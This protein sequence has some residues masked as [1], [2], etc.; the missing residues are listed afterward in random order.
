M[1]LLR[2]LVPT[3]E[4]PMARVG[5]LPLSL[6]ALGVPAATAAARGGLRRGL[7][8]FRGCGGGLPRGWFRFR[9]FGGLWIPDRDCGHVWGGGWTPHQL[10]MLVLLS[11]GHLFSRWRET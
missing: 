7:F 2:P 10:P 8:R 1:G 4:A 9:G 6:L 5:A 11:R 3:V